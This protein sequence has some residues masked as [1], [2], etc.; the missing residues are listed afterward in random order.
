M[1]R[2]R[3][4][5][6]SAKSSRSPGTR[7]LEESSFSTNRANLSSQNESSS[8]NPSKL[9]FKLRKP[10]R[11]QKAVQNPST[12]SNSSSNPS[13][14]KVQGKGEISLDQVSLLKEEL[15]LT[16]KAFK[17]TEQHKRVFLSSLLTMPKMQ[18][19]VRIAREIDTI[20]K[21]SSNIA[22][23][24][25]TIDSR[26]SKLFEIEKHL[27]VEK[28]DLFFYVKM[29][30]SLREISFK[31]ID[32]IEIW[33]NEVNCQEDFL[34]HDQS[35][36][37]KMRNDCDFIAESW[38]CRYFYLFK[39][40]P[41]F[42]GPT[43]LKRVGK[44]TYSVP[45]S[46][47]NTNRLKK[48][49]EVLGFLPIKPQKTQSEATGEVQTPAGEGLTS[50]VSLFFQTEVPSQDPE[51]KKSLVSLTKLFH[52]DLLQMSLSLNLESL[53]L[54]SCKEILVASLMLHSSSILDKIITEV[55]N[56]MIPSIARNS[57]T[58]VTDSEY[59]DIRNQVLDEVFEEEVLNISSS[60][61]NYLL[62]LSI[63]AHMFASF[64]LSL[65]VVE[66]IEEE[67]N[68]N[69][70]IVFIVAEKVLEEFIQSDLV[71]DLAEIELIDSKMEFAWVG[72]PGH[73]QREIYLKQ[74]QRIVTRLG[75]SVYF[76]MLNDFVA[77]L[78]L[79]GLVQSFLNLN[80][81][82]DE[83]IFMLKDPKAVLIEESKKPLQV[84][85]K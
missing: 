65:L 22:S 57:H 21:G 62:S 1:L 32:F 73:I 27:Q 61:T 33:K 9:I 6:F 14:P 70:K 17:I 30:E 28:F 44:R 53:V 37:E 16:W 80:D 75:E 12:R 54:E 47:K 48:A 51:Y 71:E 76:Q 5:P 13:K 15:E 39:A 29:I 11:N 10:S 3:P 85:K 36:Y 23:V 63:N 82:G 2:F 64:D 74:K 50:S 66:A 7:V 78:W 19:A 67:K 40:D 77:D 34:W 43:S 59:L 24:L 4:K 18:A 55:L 35:Y 60:I 79:E 20:E 84:R 68:E 31:V 49:Q 25:Q 52:E 46:S 83:E 38:L 8:K 56:E 42:S 69:M 81:A 26:E 41:L 72:L 45:Y 58:E